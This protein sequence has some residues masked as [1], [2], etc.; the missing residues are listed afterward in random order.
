MKI[1]MFTNAYLPMV[2]GVAKS[3]DRFSS[4][5][6]KAGHEVRIV[7]PEYDEPCPPEKEQHVFRAAATQNFDGSDFSFVLPSGLALAEWLDAFGPE[8]VHSHHPFL[9]GNSAVRYVKPRKLPLVFTHHTMYEHYTHYVPVEMDAMK[10][11]IM[12]LATGYANFC[13]AVIAPSQSTAEIIRSRGVESPIHVAPTGVDIQEYAEA[14][15]PRGRRDNEIPA[16]AFLLGTVGRMA[17]EKNLAFLAR[18][19]SA[20]MQRDR[21]VWFL[22]VG[23]GPAV[24]QMQGIFRDAGVE[25]RVRFAG[26]LKGQD[27]RDAYHA[28]DLFAF[29]SKTETQGMVLVEALAAG[30]PLLALDAPGAREVVD[31][32]RNGRLLKEEDPE[33]Y[34][35]AATE[36]AGMSDRQYAQMR[37]RARES[38]E[39]FDTQACVEKVLA[40]YRELIG[41]PVGDR[42]EYDWTKML[43]SIRQEWQIWSNRMRSLGRALGAQERHRPPEDETS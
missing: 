41:T 1:A 26:V 39:A 33:V 5:M 14:D 11:Y 21:R 27:L 34:A 2:G 22:A 15:G 12:Q 4:L 10:Q 35:D 32:A 42:P 3:V 31:D 20:A 43:E 9:L 40:I 28:M 36:I 24:E 16:E 7:A 19:V 8:V 29:A 18:A 38:A 30:C 23:S 17:P 25:N 6:R 13:D 37:R